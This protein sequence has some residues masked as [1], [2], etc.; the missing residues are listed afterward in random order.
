MESFIN[1]TDVTN[2]EN[3]TNIR[4]E[5]AGVSVWHSLSMAQVALQLPTCN[6]YPLKGSVDLYQ[7]QVKHK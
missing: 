2:R 4:D 3:V 1:K 7:I 5:T 6:P